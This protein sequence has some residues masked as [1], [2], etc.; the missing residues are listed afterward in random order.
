MKKRYLAVIALCLTIGF[1]SFA[2]TADVPRKFDEFGS[3]CCNEVKA[4]LDNFATYLLKE[5][6]A[7]GYII[8]YEGRHNSSCGSLRPTSPRRGEAQ[9]RARLMVSYL[10]D[11]YNTIVGIP[12]ALVDG[13]YREEWVTELWIVPNWNKPPKAT[14]TLEAKD[15]KFR[16]GRISEREFECMKHAR[17][18][19]T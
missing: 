6:R 12:I 13:G 19:A 8:F 11:R 9:A 15:I 2:Q 3:I 10:H 1:D 17:R 18:R 4:R 16:K 7:R 14:P 5:P